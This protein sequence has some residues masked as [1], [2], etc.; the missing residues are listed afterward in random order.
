[1]W[2]GTFGVIHSTSPTKAPAAKR[3][4]N[5][6]HSS[7]PYRWG[8]SQ[9]GLLGFPGWGDKK[10]VWLRRCKEGQR[11]CF[12]NPPMGSSPIYFQT[13]RI[14]SSQQLDASSASGR[15]G[16]HTLWRLAGDEGTVY[17][18]R[19]AVCWGFNAHSGHDKRGESLQAQHKAGGQLPPYNHEGQLASSSTYCTERKT[20]LE[21]SSPWTPATDGQRDSHDFYT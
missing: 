10:K 1:M 15:Q 5:T 4:G 17:V 9:G 19:L 12:H 7:F 18:T 21:I 13:W 16:P 20:R 2:K 11:S 3:Q 14:S 6:P 8:H